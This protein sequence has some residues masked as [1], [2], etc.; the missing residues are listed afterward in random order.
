[1][2]VKTSVRQFKK[3]KEKSDKNWIANTEYG[4]TNLSL[5]HFF[6]LWANSTAN[7]KVN[8]LTYTPMQFSNNLH[9]LFSGQIP[10]LY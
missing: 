8:S 1:M 2:Q 10:Q 5:K 3:V 9:I 7:I 6:P 4:G